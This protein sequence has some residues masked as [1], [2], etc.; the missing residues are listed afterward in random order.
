MVEDC[1]LG[2]DGLNIYGSHRSF[3]GEDRMDLKVE[4][5]NSSDI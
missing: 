5:R 3:I 1:R 4:M 2:N